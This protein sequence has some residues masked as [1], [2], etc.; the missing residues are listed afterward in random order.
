MKNKDDRQASFDFD[1]SSK[2]AIDSKG[3]VDVKTSEKVIRLVFSNES[4]IECAEPVL[5]V[6]AI[7]KRILDLAK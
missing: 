3:L 1:R 2:L 7:N 6:Y 4:R 5:D